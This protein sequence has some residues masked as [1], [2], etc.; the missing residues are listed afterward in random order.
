MCFYYFKIRPN[1][2]KI[3]KFTKTT[4]SIEICS[5]FKSR[6]IRICK[7]LKQ[8]G[9]W[10]VSLIV[11]EQVSAPENEPKSILP[12]FQDFS[13]KSLIFPRKINKNQGF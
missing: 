1:F 2:R 3:N 7:D 11:L 6:K 5:I 9:W 4:I 13:P 10:E 8:T 12:D